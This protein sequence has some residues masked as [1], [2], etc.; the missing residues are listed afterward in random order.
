MS[1][2][3]NLL[4]HLNVYADATDTNNPSMNYVKWTQDAQG[5]DIT[6][7][8]SKGIKLQAGQSIDLFSGTVT[9]SA[10]GTTTYDIALKAGTTNTYKLSHSGGTNPV[11]RTARVEGSDATTEVTVTKNAKLLTFTSTGGT[12]FDLVTGS[13]AIGDEVRLGD[14]FNASNRGKFK[15]L[16]FTATSFTIENEI[17]IAEGPITL[18][19]SFAT[20][21]N[22]FSADGVQIG[23]KIDIVDGFSS[24]THGTYEITDVSHDY[25][26]I[27]SVDSL[28][29]EAG[30]SNSPAA[31]LIY[32]DAKQFIY[33]ESDKK[34]EISLDGSVTTQIES[35]QVGTAQKPGVFMI[36]ASI[37]SATLENKSSDTA[38]IFYMTAE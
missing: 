19:A 20:E 5:I 28:P 7:P 10:D 18:G 2:K 27:Y 23:D 25:I 38:T 30:I 4:V 37:K 14:T 36:K 13:V 3:M 31:F 24:V 16:A 17:G 8:E 22:I 9:T 1:D 29:S 35:F 26:E 33:I 11:F 15:I 32:R 12:V 21:V 6:E 34:L